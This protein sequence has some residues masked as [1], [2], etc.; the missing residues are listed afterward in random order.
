VSRIISG[1]G[2]AVNQLACIFFIEK[3]GAPVMILSNREYL[4]K[5]H[6]AK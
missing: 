1:D 4:D 2:R 3:N 5:L 6:H